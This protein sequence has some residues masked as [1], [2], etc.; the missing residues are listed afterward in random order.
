MRDVIQISSVTPGGVTESA[1][2]GGLEGA[3][4]AS[5]ETALWSPPVLSPDQLINPLKT[6]ADARGRDMAMNDGHSLGAVQI[7]KDSIVGGQYRLNAQ[8]NWKVLGASQE[9][10]DE[11]QQVV[12]ARFSLMSESDACWLD[13][14]SMNTFTGMVRL[15]VGG[16]VYT[17][18][19]LATAEWL[20][21]DPSRPLST[22]I[23][24]VSPDRLRNPMDEPDGLQ[25][26]GRRLQRGVEQDARG[27][28]IAYHI[29]TTH[30]SEMFLRPDESQSKRVPRVT[31]WGRRQ[32]L[33]ILEQQ[34]PAQS[35]G[36]ADMVAALKQMRM[37]KRFEEITLQNAVVNA[38]FAAA[39]ESELPTWD[40]MNAMGGGADQNGA[41][42][43]IETYLASVGSYVGAG[44]NIQ[45]DGAKIPVFFPGT[46]LNL[47]P[48]GT[49][50]GVGS[51]FH[52]ALLRHTA[53]ALGVS[54]EELSRDFSQVSYSGAKA[55]LGVT[56][57]FMRS[58][59]K[60]V[61]DRFANMVYALVLEEEIAKGNVPLPTGMDRRQ[62]YEPLMKEAFTACSWIGAGAQEIDPLKEVQASIM[63]IKAG[64][65]TYE[66]EIAKYGDDWREVFQQRAREEKLANTLQLG[67]SL[68]ATKAG[69][70]E[71]QQTMT[72]KG[73]SK[74]PQGAKK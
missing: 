24:M 38:S 31:K 5:R 51:D 61:A 71:R 40:V 62:F 59:K 54:Y 17:G 30:P 48:M 64:L 2:G 27:A 47:K 72:D 74:A 7:H 14:S 43:F 58:R 29:R 1:M 35:R 4:R 33:H 63:K 3:A 23:Q 46:K 28:P 22:A 56:E 16:F 8:P 19:V 32:V 50:G 68:E 18:E 20:D 37:T 53:A 25:P 36:I 21:K 34:F 15:A 57:R 67:F 52:E 65:S 6:M 39:I 44:K 10:A 12:E 45:I 70:N 66:K 69:K 26:D 13:A 49:P 9:W 55:S 60:S 42:K 11:F 73:G 41:L